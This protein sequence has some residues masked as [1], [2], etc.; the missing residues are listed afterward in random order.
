MPVQTAMR[1]CASDAKPCEFLKKKSA[2][3][4]SGEGF[5]RPALEPSNEDER[6]S[7]NQI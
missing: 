3:R 1:F 6:G 4:S 2:G 7:M 5:V